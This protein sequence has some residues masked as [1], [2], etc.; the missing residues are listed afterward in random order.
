[1]CQHNKQPVLTVVRV[2]LK[3]GRSRTLPYRTAS[4]AG[5]DSC[6]GHAEQRFLG[7]LRRMN[8]AQ[9]AFPTLIRSIYV[10]VYGPGC[11]N[12]H[13]Q[14]MNVLGRYQ[15]ASRLQYV[16]QTANPQPQQ[17]Y[18]C[19]CGTKAGTGTKFG[20]NGWGDAWQSELTNSQKNRVRR[21][22]RRQADER[23]MKRTKHRQIDHGEPL[24]QAHLGNATSQNPNERNLRQVTVRVHEE[25]EKLWNAW[26]RSTFYQRCTTPE[27]RKRKLQEIFTQLRKKYPNDT[28]SRAFGQELELLELV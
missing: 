20:Q 27:Q 28:I 11:S 3:N 21:E 13:A 4:R 5:C 12:C 25:K 22:A 18:F 9:P 14:L 1:M 10:R 23:G 24:A 6:A 26:I 15:L 19:G 16:T 2:F 17:P 8:A 7:W